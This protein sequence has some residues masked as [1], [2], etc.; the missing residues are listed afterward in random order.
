MGESVGERVG[1]RVGLKVLSKKSCS[2]LRKEM[3]SDNVTYII[4][5]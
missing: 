4:E 3:L 1:L 2:M 5:L